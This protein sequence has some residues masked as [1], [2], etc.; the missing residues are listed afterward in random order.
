MQFSQNK[1]KKRE[2][3]DVALTVGVQRVCQLKVENKRVIHRR[4]DVKLNF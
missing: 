2:K 1:E 3:K 4:A